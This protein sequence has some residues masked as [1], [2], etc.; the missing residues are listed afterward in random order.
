[1]SKEAEVSIALLA[2]ACVLQRVVEFEALFA[3]GETEVTVYD[4]S[5]DYS[6]VS[7]SIPVGFN[8]HEA[9]LV[10]EILKWAGHAEPS[11]HCG[12]FLMRNLCV[13]VRYDN[14]EDE[15]IVCIVYNFRGDNA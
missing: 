9:L 11:G 4:E 7:V 8:A 3:I 6:N 1:M 10:D 15:D 14:A 5:T 12:T 2:Q 13:A